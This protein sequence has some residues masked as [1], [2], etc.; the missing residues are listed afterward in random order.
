VTGGESGPA[1]GAARSL[2]QLFL[3]IGSFELSVSTLLAVAGAAAA[4]VATRVG[5]R[6][7]GLPVRRSVDALGAMIAFGLVA[8]H[9][10]DVIL[11]RPFEL[12]GGGWRALAPTSGGVCSLGA[13]AGA[14][15]VGWLAL[16]RA[17]GGLASHADNLVT[18]LC[19]GWAI[20]RLGCF[21]DHDHLGRLTGSPL[22]VSFPGGAR[23]DLGL[24][25]AALALVLFVIAAARLRRIPRPLPGATAALSAL[26]FAAGRFGIECLR[27]DDLAALGRH[28]DARFFGLT[29][30]QY[31][32]AA[33]AI[34]A[35]IHLRATSS[36]NR[37]R[38]GT[39]GAA[40]ASVAGQLGRAAG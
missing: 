22:G 11:Y 4:I 7:L 13:I 26:L 36:S 20:G 10:T 21:I 31:A 18:A 24:Y 16:R 2:A 14:A 35:A 40:G 15:L 28:S 17:P 27:A 8:G 34:G 5:A 29:L 37:V 9:V 25:E 12:V 33:L 32:A 6:R 23:H 19:L 3:Q 38:G 39:P 1:T 30:V